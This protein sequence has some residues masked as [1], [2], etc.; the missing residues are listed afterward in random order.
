MTDRSLD[1][2]KEAIL[3]ERRGR[4]F[5]MKIAGQ[6]ENQAVREFFETMAAEEMQHIQIL[7]EQ[8]KSYAANQSFTSMEVSATEN[9]PL[10]ELVLSFKVRQQI[11]KADFEAAAI[12][13]AMLMEE[14]AVTL[15]GQR[16]EEATEANEKALYQWLSDWEKGHLA[17]LAKVD[18][19]LKESIWNDN[20]FWPF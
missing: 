14:R 1:I 5:Y 18:Q 19:E 11:A 4:A 2:L 17:F 10:P 9:K 3:L 8:L 13:A 16:A 20:Q 7:G 6:A 15:Y 12:S